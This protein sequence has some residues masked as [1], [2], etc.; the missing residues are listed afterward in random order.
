MGKEESIAGKKKAHNRPSAGKSRAELHERL[1]RAG[2]PP[3]EDLPTIDSAFD[4]QCHTVFDVRRFSANELRED[5][6]D[7]PFETKKLLEDSEG[8]ATWIHVSGVHAV[9]KL[10]K[11]GELLDLHPLTVEDVMNLW[12]RPRVDINKKELF[13]TGKAVNIDSETSH[14]KSQQISIVL[15]ED[16]LVSFSENEEELFRSVIA[17]LQIPNSR[18]RSS[19]A[20]FLAYSLIDTLVD[21]LLILTEAVEEIVVDMEE[22]M[23]GESATDDP[24]PIGEIYRRKR[25]VLRL[26]RIAF[27]LRDA[28]HD[29][30]D[31]S[32]EI[33]DSSLGIYL[34]DLLDH[35]R[36][37]AERV[38]HARGM[39]HDLQD[40]HSARQDNRINRTMQ[41]LTVIGTIFVPLTFVAGVYGMNFNPQTSPWNMPLLDNYW[42][43][44]ICMAGMFLFAIAMVIYFRKKKWL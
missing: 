1:E 33:L 10:Q 31:L 38:E 6:T 2:L 22:Q 37:A 18:I 32:S 40:F 25:Q 21:R 7:D 28:I 8:M 26:N 39:L 42:G 3:G 35:A 9:E 44:P 29:L 15:R 24:I 11:L 4:R 34:R 16:L 36:R 14:P 19:G 30:H 17:R 12:A 20:S 13:F 43:Y 23:L 41:L 5:R 27:P